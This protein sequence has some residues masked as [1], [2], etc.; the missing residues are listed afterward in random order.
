MVD[1]LKLWADRVIVGEQLPTIANYLD[2]ARQETDLQTGEVR[3]YGNIEGLKV[4]IYTGGL[5]VIGSMPKF[6]YGSHEMWLGLTVILEYV[7][8]SYFSMEIR[9]AI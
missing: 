1:K 4:A 5:S 2:S 7:R 6:L 3:T 8:R 9:S